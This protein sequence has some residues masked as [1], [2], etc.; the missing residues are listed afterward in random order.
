MG[1]LGKVRRKTVADGVV[2]TVTWAGS[3]VTNVVRNRGR[4]VW[5]D[6]HETYTVNRAGCEATFPSPVTE[7]GAIT[8]RSLR[9]ETEFLNTVLG[10]LEADD[11]FWDVG[12]NLG[13][14]ACLATDRISEGSIVAVE[15]DP[16]NA[17][18]LRANLARN[19]AESVH[20]I[21]AA[22]GD[23][24]DTVPFAVPES[25]D[26]PT[27]GTVAGGAA[28]PTDTMEV[29]QRRLETLV[30][31]RD[32]PAPTVMKLD[33]EGGEALAI[34]GMEQAV[35]A[36]RVLFSEVHRS[37][38]AAQSIQSFGMTV[39]EYRQRLASMGFE[40]VVIGE[41]GAELQLE[42]VNTGLAGDRS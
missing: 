32:V 4:H 15:P 8:R 35:E 18:Q 16:R 3:A 6:L 10:E 21:E 12:A 40:H 33:I 38:A 25:D 42:S 24:D 27:R 19:D 26:F 39:E 22:V 31:E 11:V 20:V 13:V 9:L 28:E 37:D 36:C 2:P 34:Q 17:A 29:P 1:L 14:Y 5:Y 41:R 23:T 30:Q 7:G